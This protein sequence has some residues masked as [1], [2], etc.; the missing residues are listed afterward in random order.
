[1]SFATKEELRQQVAALKKV[2]ERQRRDQQT[3]ADSHRAEMAAL[4]QEYKALEASYCQARI[5]V[6][7]AYKRG[8]EAARYLPRIYHKQ[9]SKEEARKAADERIRQA[10]FAKDVGLVKEEGENV[11][12]LSDTWSQGW[13]H[14]IYTFG[15]K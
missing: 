1:M 3:T 7:S 6:E 4:R 15:R 5:E 8:I 14:D 9:P 2:V 13:T 12:A 11:E 10:M